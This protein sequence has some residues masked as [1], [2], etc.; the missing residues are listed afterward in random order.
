M[1]PDETNRLLARLTQSEDPWVERKQSFD[2]RELRKT[3]VGFANSVS[4]LQTAVMFIGAD[5]KGRH[6]GV[7]DGDDMQKKVAGA[8]Q[9]CY[10]RIA[11]QTCV[12]AVEIE[13]KPLEILAILVPFSQNR[14]HFTG[15]AYVRR[16]SETI[17][18]SEFEFLE[19]VASQNDVARRILQFKDKR[20]WLRLESRSGFWFDFECTVRS[21]DAHS[22]TLCDDSS[23]LWSFPIPSIQIKG[24]PMR[25]LEIIAA[26][27]GTEEEH[28][29]EMV[30]RWVRFRK[31][32]APGEYQLP[33][34]YLVT[35]LL[36]NPV[37]VLPVVA[38]FAHGSD[39]LWLRL[40]HLHLRFAVKQRGQPI[41][42]HQKLRRLEAQFAHRME[43]KLPHSNADLISTA[44]HSVVEVATSLNECEEFLKLLV[45]HHSGISNVGYQTLWAAILWELKL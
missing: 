19:L 6:K 3:V 25:E 15:P 21:C 36:A 28:I 22:V 1:N 43:G 11:Y 42:R 35:Q 18:A 27:S 32:P 31:P 7:T 23:T 2:E 9:R 40:L 39:N 8:L 24:T 5:N 30:D 14:P 4:E 26:A 13:G 45:K 17:E 29:R 34:N 20:C 33:S 37:L 10:P 16:G 38:A 41:P 44:V 12:L